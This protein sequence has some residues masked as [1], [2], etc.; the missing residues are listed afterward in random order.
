MS[1][2]RIATILFQ[3]LKRSFKLEVYS[4]YPCF[5]P[6]LGY[7]YEVYTKSLTKVIMLSSFSKCFR[8]SANVFKQWLPARNTCPNI[9]I[10]QSTVGTRNSIVLLYF[11]ILLFLWSSLF[12]L[13][14]WN[15]V[16]SVFI[17]FVYLACEHFVLNTLVY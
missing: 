2:K 15:N 8:E 17:S 9:A 11:I 14:L 6:Y 4:S 1:C 12:S 13:S 7:S 10:H 16:R 5:F 3:K